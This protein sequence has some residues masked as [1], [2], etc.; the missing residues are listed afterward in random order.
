MKITTSTK[1]LSFDSLSLEL[2]GTT[3]TREELG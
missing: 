3:V 2:S 1:S